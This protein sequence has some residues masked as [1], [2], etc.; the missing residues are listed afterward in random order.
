VEHAK[1]VKAFGQPDPE[2]GLRNAKNVAGQLEK[3][4][5]GAAAMRE[6]LAEMFSVAC[7][8]TDGRLAKTLT[9][10]SR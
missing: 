9:R 3:D 1:L 10:W 5:P 6:V 4:Y 2:Q 7:L 8:G